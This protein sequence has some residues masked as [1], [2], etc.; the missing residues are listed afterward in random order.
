MSQD[1]LTQLQ[2]GRLSARAAYAKGL[3]KTR[4]SRHLA[5]HFGKVI[6]STFSSGET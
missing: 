2:S 3:I 1:T 6:G 4:G 5:S